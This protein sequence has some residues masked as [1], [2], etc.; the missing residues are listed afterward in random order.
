MQEC[1]AVTQSFEPKCREVCTEAE[2]AR[3]K[4]AF[5]EKK[6]NLAMLSGEKNED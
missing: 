5:F 2:Y 4:Q 6:Q 3:L 1:F